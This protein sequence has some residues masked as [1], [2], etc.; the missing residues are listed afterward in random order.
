MKGLV[1]HPVNRGVV[2]K[3]DEVRI[4]IEPGCYEFTWA[5]QQ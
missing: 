5:Q 3:A 4:E 1:G 2:E